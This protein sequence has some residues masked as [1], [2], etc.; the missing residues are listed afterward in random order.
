MS[1]NVKDILEE[2][3][4]FIGRNKVGEELLPQGILLH[5]FGIYSVGSE[6]SRKPMWVSDDY[7][8]AKL[9]E[10]HAAA[11]GKTIYYSTFISR[12]GLKILDLEGVSL[13]QGCMDL[14]VYNHH[15]WNMLL[16]AALETLGFDGLVYCGREIHI[17]KPF[18]VLE[19]VRSSTLW[20]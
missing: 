1:S 16:A 20:A 15:K 8:S 19:P 11:T 17:S 10:K 12:K 13:M 7:V 3:R 6:I 2:T 14:K 18:E 9:Y 4:Y 5:H